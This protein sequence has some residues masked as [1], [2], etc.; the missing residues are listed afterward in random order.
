MPFTSS[1]NGGV[2]RPAGTLIDTGALSTTLT[3]GMRNSIA[4]YCSPPSPR[5][6]V[7][8]LSATT[9]SSTR[10]RAYVS[11]VFAK[12]DTSHSPVMSSSTT[13]A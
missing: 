10:S 4:E 2:T 12:N 1:T 9:A 8:T 7:R 3:L 11:Y 13:S 6:R 5:S